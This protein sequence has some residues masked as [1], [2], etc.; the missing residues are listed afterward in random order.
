MD[1]PQNKNGLIALQAWTWGYLA[2]SFSETL[3]YIEGI[4]IQESE[5]LIKLMPGITQLVAEVQSW[6]FENMETVTLLKSSLDQS[7]K[8]ENR[9]EQGR[10]KGVQG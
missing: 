2:L 1:H 9:D 4:L 7:I 5:G 8:S 3:M 10:G 6:S